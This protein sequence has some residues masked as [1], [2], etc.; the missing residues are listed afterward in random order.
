MEIL[1]DRRHAERAIVSF[2]EIL[3]AIKMISE[4]KCLDE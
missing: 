1:C 2:G 4:S 3:Q